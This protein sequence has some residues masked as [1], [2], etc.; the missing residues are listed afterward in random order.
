MKSK[1]FSRSSD[2]SIVKPRVRT[3]DSEFVEVVTLRNE[4]LAVGMKRW[5]SPDAAVDLGEGG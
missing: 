3:I 4:V 5:R 2:D 1:C